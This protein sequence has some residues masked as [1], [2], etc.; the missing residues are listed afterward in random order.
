MGL[1]AYVNDDEVMGKLSEYGEMK[2]LVMRLKC[3][4]EHQLAGLENGKRLI[5]IALTAQPSLIRF[6]LAE[7]G[8]ALSTATSN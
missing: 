1:K 3:R 4:K 5:H 8:V 6:K 2:A 7:S